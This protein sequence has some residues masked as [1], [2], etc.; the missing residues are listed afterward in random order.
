MPSIWDLVTGK[1]KRKDVSATQAEEERQRKADAEAAA[2]AKAEAARKAAE[3]KVKEIRFAKGGM[4][5]G[6]GAAQR[7]KTRGKVC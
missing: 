6:D 2:A 4:V 5:R 3:D 7:G 1:A